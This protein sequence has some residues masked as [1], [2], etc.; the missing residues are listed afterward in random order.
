MRRKGGS[1]MGLW[2]VHFGG[3]DIDLVCADFFVI[4]KHTLYQ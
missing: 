3:G 2:L 1:P 4:S